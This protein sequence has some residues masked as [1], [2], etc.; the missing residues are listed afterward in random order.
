M[1]TRLKNLLPSLSA[2]EQRVAEV[3]LKQPQW[4]LDAPIAKLAA[5]AQVSQ[6]TVVRFCRSLKFNGYPDF[7]LKL[8]QS[9]ATDSAPGVPYVH[10]DVGASDSTAEIVS[11]VFDR[12]AA[13]L[14]RVAKS[15]DTASIDA[16]IK[17]LTRARRIEFYGHGN[18]SIV[19]Q[20]AQYKFFRLGAPAVHY[21]DSH[22]NRLSAPLLGKDDLVV[23]ISASG[24]TRELCRSVEMAANAGATIVA[25][26]VPNSPLS[27]LAHISIE[28]EI[29]EDPDIYSPMTSRIVHLTIIDALAVGVALKRGPKWLVNLEKSKDE[30]QAMRLPR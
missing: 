19:A 21:A 22:M 15:L 28:S 26:T 11:K 4:V 17:A 27:K 16:A 1:L 23:A 24:R 2:S 3:V 7:R 6:P 13:T 29:E 25:I 10:R 30:L 8:A 14:L 20:D 5:K 9:L 12:G 18:S